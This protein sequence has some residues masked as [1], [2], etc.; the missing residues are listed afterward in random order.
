MDQGSESDAVKRSLAEGGLVPGPAEDMQVLRNFKSTV[1][2]EVSYVGTPVEL[3]TLFPASE[4]RVAP[5]IAFA[6]EVRHLDNYHSMESNIS[7]L[8]DY[9]TP[10]VMTLIS[11]PHIH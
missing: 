5:A 9:I 1:N 7:S 2:L 3:G 6:P 4:C 8:A 11:E 10:R